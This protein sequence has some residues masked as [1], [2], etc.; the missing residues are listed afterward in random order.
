M[1]KVAATKLSGKS[2][3]AKTGTKA[4]LLKRIKE[5][6]TAISEKN[7]EIN[8]ITDELIAHH[9]PHKVGDRI[10]VNHGYSHTG[11]QMVVDSVTVSL[12]ETF[13]DKPGYIYQGR[14]IVGSGEPG[15]RTAKA[16]A[17]LK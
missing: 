9:S 13:F 15:N 2:A 14:V 1:A 6:Q 10:T 7:K 3:P 4:Q 17:P 12:K 11:K 8:T 5:A 16:F